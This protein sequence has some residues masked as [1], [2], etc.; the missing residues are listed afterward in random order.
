MVYARTSHNQAV[1]FLFLRAFYSCQK[2]FN[3][4]FFNYDDAVNNGT[5]ITS[6]FHYTPCLST[7]G[8]IHLPIL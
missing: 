8:F 4:L 7:K 6:N 1:D 3:K 2:H 5:I